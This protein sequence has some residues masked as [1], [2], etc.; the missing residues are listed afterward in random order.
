[1]S[2]NQSYLFRLNL[3]DEAVST[4]CSGI[5]QLH[6]YYYGNVKKT[7]LRSEVFSPK[8]NEINIVNGSKNY[9]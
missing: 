2:L 1:M 8:N 7:D 6:T 9:F 3:W 5:S 4:F